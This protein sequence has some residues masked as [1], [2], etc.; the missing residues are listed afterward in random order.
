MRLQ[1]LRACLLWVLAS[2]ANAAGG[3]VLSAAMTGQPLVYQKDGQVN[4]C[5]VRFVAVSAFNSRKDAVRIVDGSFMVS[6]T[7]YG[8]VKAGMMTT[9]GGAVLDGMKNTKQVRTKFFWLRRAGGDPTTPT[10]GKVLASPED[11]GFLFYGISLEAAMDLLTALLADG[12]E[13]EVGMEPVGSGT[14]WVL[15][16]KLKLEEGETERISDCMEALVRGL[17]R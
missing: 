1:I 7:G 3:P 14:A 4:G 10:Q 15:A 6:A 2:A 8:I 9:T 11:A 17:K 13:L 5:G 12:K 16:G